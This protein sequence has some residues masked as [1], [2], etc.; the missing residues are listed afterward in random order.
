M[1]NAQPDKCT[2]SSC[3]AVLW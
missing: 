2:L 1:I 3:L